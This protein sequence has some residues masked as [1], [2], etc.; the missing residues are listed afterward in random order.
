MAEKKN[1]PWALTIPC[2]IRK[3]KLENALCDLDASINLM[4]FAIYT[5]LGLST[6]TPTLIRLLMSNRSFKK[7]A[8]VLFDMLLKVDKFILLM[9]FVVLDYEM[10]KEVTII[11]GR[12]FLAVERAI[13]DLELGEIRFRVHDGEV[14]FWACVMEDYDQVCFMAPECHT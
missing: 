9:D 11:L 10:D 8:G 3:H 5:I 6:P 14:S 12:T 1:D 2:T 4:P 7:S 13:F